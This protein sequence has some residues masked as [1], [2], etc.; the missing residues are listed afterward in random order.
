MLTTDV[1]DV[2]KPDPA[3]PGGPT[4]SNLEDG[5][6][7]HYINLT[8]NDEVK[9][10]TEFEANFPFKCNNR[11]IIT[12]PTITVVSPPPGYIVV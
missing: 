6:N 1:M 12:S 3:L 4:R 8:I 10:V 5:L 7:T 11:V 9:Q 2:S